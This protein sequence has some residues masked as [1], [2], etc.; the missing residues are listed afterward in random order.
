M[1]T[2][3][4]RDRHGAAGRY[5][6]FIDS[7]L[8]IGAFTLAATTELSEGQRPREEQTER[9]DACLVAAS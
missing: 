3:T 8:T 2:G 6:A 7:P 5:W 1:Y 4:I 9:D